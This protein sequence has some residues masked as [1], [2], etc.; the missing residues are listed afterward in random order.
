M[1]RGREEIKLDERIYTPA[2]LFNH[3][4]S[5]NIKIFI[6]VMIEYEIILKSV[7]LLQNKVCKWRSNLHIFWNNH[8]V[9]YSAEAKSLASKPITMAV[10]VGKY[11]RLFE[12]PLLFHFRSSSV[13]SLGAYRSEYLIYKAILIHSINNMV[14][15]L[16]STFTW[17][18]GG[19]RSERTRGTSRTREA[20]L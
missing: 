6:F 14:P 11:L 15:R 9:E 18:R 7:F 16:V 5:I 13:G 4:S 12:Y 8:L 1:E 20:I 3:H 10:T 19:S 17:W 2:L